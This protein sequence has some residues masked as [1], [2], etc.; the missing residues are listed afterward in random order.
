MILTSLY[1]VI[2]PAALGRNLR[3]I[4]PC[5]SFNAGSLICWKATDDGGRIEMRTRNGPF[6]EDVIPAVHGGRKPFTTPS[7]RYQTFFPPL[8]RG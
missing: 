5:T 3:I 1:F 7:S 6:G 4:Q 2:A 8:K